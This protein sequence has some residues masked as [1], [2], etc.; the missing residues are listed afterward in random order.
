MLR[1]QQLLW[2]MRLAVGITG[3][4]AGGLA[5][6]TGRIHPSARAVPLALIVVGAVVAVHALLD[7]LWQT[8]SINDTKKVDQGAQTAQNATQ[9]VA[10]A[11]TAQDI[12][13]A[14]QDV[15][16]AIQGAAQNPQSGTLTAAIGAFVAAMTTVLGLLAVFS[17]SPTS[18][19]RL[20]AL[21]L[22]IGVIVGLMILPFVAY[23]PDGARTASMLAWLTSLLFGTAA[24]GL[25]CIGF[26]IYF[27]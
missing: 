27:R 12:V 3:V 15:A 22:V 24:F 4:I 8:L 9:P 11:Q 20:G 1:N 23:G 26:A 18:A 10:S 19:V 2:W 7:R 17:P 21:I 16:Q 13:K 5:Y 6:P 14:V 25:A